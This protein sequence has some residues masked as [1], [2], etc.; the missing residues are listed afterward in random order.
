MKIYPRILNIGVSHDLSTNEYT[1]LL[2]AKKAKIPN[3]TM[4]APD[5]VLVYLHV[6]DISDWTDLPTNLFGCRTT[7]M[8]PLILE[9]LT[10]SDI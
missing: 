5:E 8:K 7:L 2:E 10:T 3:S 9:P 4:R 6:E 1:D